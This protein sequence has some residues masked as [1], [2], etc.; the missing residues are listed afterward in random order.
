MTGCCDEAV[1]RV[2]SL[3]L[4]SGDAKC[5]WGSGREVW[6][7]TLGTYTREI[8]WGVVPLVVHHLLP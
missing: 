6:A 2:D 3:A 5:K 4:A 1:M 8:T 7:M